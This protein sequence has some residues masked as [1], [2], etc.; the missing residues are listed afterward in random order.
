MR[1]DTKKKMKYKVWNGARLRLVR[2][3]DDYNFVELENKF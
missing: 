2:I 3:A 1:S